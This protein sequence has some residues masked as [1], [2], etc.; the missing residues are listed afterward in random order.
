MFEVTDESGFLALIVPATYETFVSED[1]TLDQIMAHFK[2]QMMRRSLVI[3]GTGIDGCWKV[4]VRQTTTNVKGFRAFCGSLQ[5]NGGKLL[6]T[7]YESLTMAAQFDDVTLPEKHQENLLVAVPDG[8]YTCRI[9]QMFNPEQEDS[10]ADDEPDFI[11]ELLMA[12]KTFPLEN[13][14]WYKANT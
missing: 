7:N 9:I 14:P 3:W 13:I 11:I 1:W 10:A 8:D 6:V 2:T 4:D 12:K 5:V